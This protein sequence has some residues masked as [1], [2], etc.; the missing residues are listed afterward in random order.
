MREIEFR[1]KSLHYDWL[2][3]SY[4]QRGVSQTFIAEGLCHPETVLPKTIGQY[5]GLKD[6]NG[7]KI[8]EGD[9]IVYKTMNLPVRWDVEHS[10]F[11]IG[12][13]KYWMM[14]APDLEVIGNIH[15]N[16]ELLEER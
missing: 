12:N 8:F 15:D 7:V 6:K 9:I 5:T 1:G 13:D 11:F 3:G 16:H 10:G 4:L 2:Y 14:N